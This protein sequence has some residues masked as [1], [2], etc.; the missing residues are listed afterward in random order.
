LIEAGGKVS[1]IRIEENRQVGI[2]MGALRYGEQSPYWT[3][4]NMEQPGTTSDRAGDNKK[5]DVE[6][7]M[8]GV[9]V[10]RGG[11][12]DDLVVQEIKNL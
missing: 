11:E 2:Q 10:S 12:N 6:R 1:V 3:E 8:V 5:G 7:A 4:S 9:N